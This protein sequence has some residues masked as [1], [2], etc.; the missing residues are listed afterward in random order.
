M[1][2]LTRTANLVQIRRA[3]MNLTS[4]WQNKTESIKKMYQMKTMT[5]SSKLAM[6]EKST[7]ISGPQNLGAFHHLAPLKK[8]GNS[9]VKKKLGALRKIQHENSVPWHKNG[10]PVG[11]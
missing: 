5:Y 4:L 10:Q 2:S 3:R 9:A 8:S 7:I 11:H 6:T 1:I